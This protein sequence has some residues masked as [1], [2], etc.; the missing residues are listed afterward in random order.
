MKVQY[1]CPHNHHKCFETPQIYILE[2]QT[3]NESSIPSKAFSEAE[4][5][6]SFSV[7]AF[8]FENE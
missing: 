3:C 7:S 2:Q 1:K 4:I 8:V 5:N 6:E